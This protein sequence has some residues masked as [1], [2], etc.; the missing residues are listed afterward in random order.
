MHI[1]HNFHDNRSSSL[2]IENEYH[3]SR[4]KGG[5]DKETFWEV[6]MKGLSKITNKFVPKTNDSKG[7][8]HV[9]DDEEKT[10]WIIYSRNRMGSGPISPIPEYGEERFW[11]PATIWERT[12]SHTSFTAGEPVRKEEGSSGT[13]TP[14]SLGGLKDREFT[15]AFQSTPLITSISSGLE[16]IPSPLPTNNRHRRASMQDAIDFRKIDSKLY[17]RRA[18]RRQRSVASIEEDPLGSIHFSVDF[19]QETSLLTVYIIEAENLTAREF[20]GTA[21]PYCK[22]R[23]L[24]DR[25]T[26]LQSKIHR[27]TTDP[28]FDEEFIFEIEP[29][30]LRTM[31][32]E[33]LIYDYD[34]FSRHE[35]I[36]QVKLT[37]DS[38]DIST[39]QTYWKPLVKRDQKCNEDNGDIIFSLGYLSSAERLT[40][41]VMKARNLR[42]IE[43]GKITMDP[44]VKILL[45]PGPGKKQKKKKTSTK[46]NVMN[47]VWNEALTFSL[48]N[49]CLQNVSMEFLVC[50]DNK[51]GNDEI[52]GR[53]II[54]RDS[55]GDERIHWDE[56][57]NCRSA[58]ARW[59]S[60]H[61]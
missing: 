46:H 7:G 31:T 30:I 5:H 29:D 56:M 24:P 15:Y 12:R 27:K 20:S 50:H 6:L 57:V 22:V 34:Q 53:S 4:P 41:V 36:G 16:D 55:S 17:D 58:V 25:R 33:L 26:Q 28:I 40:V 23:L 10:E 37:L 14:A 43:E 32:L 19:N 49:E 9:V 51:I 44:Y 61:L 52:L 45:N 13:T 59:H 47:P 42:H 1:L 3:N 11:V 39:R 54:S 60:L 18:L 2:R 48:P 38:I 35:C 21:D 8:D